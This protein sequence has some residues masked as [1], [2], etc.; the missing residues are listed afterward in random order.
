M[1]DKYSIQ[2]VFN[3]IGEEYLS[4]TNASERKLNENII[5]EGFRVRKISLRYMTFYRNLNCVC[6]GR[7]GSYF[8]LE[9]G[10]RKGPED[11]RHFNLYSEDN[12]LMTKDHI[13]PKSQGGENTVFN[14]Q[15]MCQECNSK[16]GANYIK[17]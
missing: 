7:K 5:V 16:K 12:I 8:K 10:D 13:L 9:R 14:M 3:L 6:C 15:T 2:E 17:Y 1:K 4:K 11:R